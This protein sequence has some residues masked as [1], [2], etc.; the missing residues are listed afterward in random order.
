[1]NFIQWN[2]RYIDLIN[3]GDPEQARE[4]FDD[5]IAENKDPFRKKRYLW[6]LIR[7]KS[8][9]TVLAKWIIDQVKTAVGS[10]GG[11]GPVG[12]V[13]TSGGP[14]SELFWTMRVLHQVL[15]T[16]KNF[17]QR[18]SLIWNITKHVSLITIDTIPYLSEE[19]FT[20]LLKGNRPIIYDDTLKPAV[21]VIAELKNE[22]EST[23]RTLETM[24]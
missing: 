8:F 9:Y 21:M 11:N 7:G 15:E 3:C 17:N 20:N 18:R 16:E 23:Q 1:M 2:R 13:D 19:R 4:F 24:L 10:D 5:L 6:N 12:I 22:L 14:K